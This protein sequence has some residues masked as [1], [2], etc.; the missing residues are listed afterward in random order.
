MPVVGER[1]PALVRQSKRQDED[2]VGG[3]GQGK[4]G[5]DIEQ[6]QEEQKSRSR[7]EWYQR[8]WCNQYPIPLLSYYIHN[9]ISYNVDKCK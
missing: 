5:T 1:A 4:G 7:R 6:S 8:Q 2:M 9:N 3:T